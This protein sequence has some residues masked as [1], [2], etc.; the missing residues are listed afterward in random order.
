M[1]NTNNTNITNRSSNFIPAIIY[2]NAE[3]NKLT[4]LSDNKNRTG[5]YQW[6]HNESGKIYVGSAINLSKRLFAYYSKSNITNK[7]SYIYNALFLHSH[8]SF[9][10]TILEY[11]DISNLDNTKIKKLL[12]EREQHYIDMFN[13]EYNILK[14]AGN[15]LGFKHSEDILDKMSFVQKNINR[16][17]ENNPMFGK[18]GENSPRYGKILTDITK[19]KM[20]K[21]KLGEKNPFYE[22]SHNEET[23]KK[24]KLVMLGE[25]NPKSKKVFVYF[26]DN[27]T[28]LLFEFSTYTE[29][30]KYFN[31]SR[32]TI[33]K[34]IDNNKIYQDKWI[35]F[36]SS[37]N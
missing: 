11:I 14:V 23:L 6:T 35:L 17:G 16:S 20:S 18:S 3:I 4:I 33:S 37:Q 2:N 24:I 28:K 12:L 26:K 9:N 25:N 30:G 32:K 5:I 21:A 27:L 36:S 10:L 22:K 1:V 8:S 34:Y 31:C 15:S 19:D 7:K 29:A 13:P